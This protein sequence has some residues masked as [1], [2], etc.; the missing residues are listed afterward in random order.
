MH[1]K[2]GARIMHIYLVAHVV[3]EKLLVPESWRARLTVKKGQHQILAANANHAQ[4]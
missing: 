1:W 2:Q 4:I 3:A